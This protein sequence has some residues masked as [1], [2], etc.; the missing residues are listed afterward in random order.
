[1]T[2]PFFSFFFIA[3]RILVKK[4]SGP[5]YSL[6]HYENPRGTIARR[7]LVRTWL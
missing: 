1:M 6:P 2:A 5:S 4:C 7:I 3:R